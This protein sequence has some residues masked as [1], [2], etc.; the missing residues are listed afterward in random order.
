MSDTAAKEY[1]FEQSLDN[2]IADHF[3][4]MPWSSRYDLEEFVKDLVLHS[5][6]GF[7]KVAVEAREKKLDDV[8]N[9]RLD[10]LKGQCEQVIDTHLKLL[11][12]K[13][14]KNIRDGIV[15]GLSEQIDDCYVGY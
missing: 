6:A 10:A 13:Y 1:K 3:P 11:K 12:S 9:S 7:V 2:Y 5:S 15:N 14:K 4:E 8:Y